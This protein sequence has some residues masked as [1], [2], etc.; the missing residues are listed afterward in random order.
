MQDTH[1][2]KVILLRGFL[3]FFSLSSL[4]F[5]RL[6]RARKVSHRETA[7]TDGTQFSDGRKEGV[8]R[9][10]LLQTRDKRG[11]VPSFF[12][13]LSAKGPETLRHFAAIRGLE[14]GFFLYS[15]IGRFA[16]SKIDT[17][18]FDSLESP[19]LGMF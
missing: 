13:L 3:S 10:G 6:P 4:F 9:E 8:R 19:I 7:K 5:P 16:R 14:S 17:S 12:S 2:V 11:K 18:I 1:E 15:R